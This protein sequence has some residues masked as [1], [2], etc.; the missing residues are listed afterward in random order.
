MNQS[1]VQVFIDPALVKSLPANHCWLGGDVR[2]D[3]WN[4]ACWWS[5]L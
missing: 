5:V 2:C 3:E 4:Q 1:Q